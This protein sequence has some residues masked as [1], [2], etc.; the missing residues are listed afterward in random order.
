MFQKHFTAIETVYLHNIKLFSA[1]FHLDADQLK[2]T[3]KLDIVG[4]ASCDGQIVPLDGSTCAEMN[5]ALTSHA[6]PLWVT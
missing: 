3:I 5:E 4:R 1:T 6:F 2:V